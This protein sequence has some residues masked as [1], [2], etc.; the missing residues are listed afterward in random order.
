[1]VTLDLQHTF[2]ALCNAELAETVVVAPPAPPE[3]A[4]VGLVLA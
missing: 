2:T 4:A 3:T 1:M